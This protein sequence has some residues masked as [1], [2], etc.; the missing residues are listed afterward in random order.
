MVSIK[1][2]ELNLGIYKKQGKGS[3]HLYKGEK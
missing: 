3:W 1:E 2:S